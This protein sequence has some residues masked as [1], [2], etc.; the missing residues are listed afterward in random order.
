[1]LVVVDLLDIKS[2]VLLIESDD[3]PVPFRFCIPVSS[4]F[5]SLTG[6]V[7]KLLQPDAATHLCEC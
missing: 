1:M 4:T 2:S 3:P 7:V 6:P 5:M